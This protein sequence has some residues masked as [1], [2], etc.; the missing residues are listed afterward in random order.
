MQPIIDWFVGLG[1]FFGAV[2]DFV[3][4]FFQDIAYIVKLLGE[5]VIAIPSYF[6]WLPGE[7]LALIVTLLGL[8]VVYM[9][10]GRK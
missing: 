3:V 10:V 6:V 7:V 9:V 1:D 5:F 8:V 2:V 4:G